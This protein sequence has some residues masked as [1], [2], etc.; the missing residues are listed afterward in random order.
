MTKN[1]ELIVLILVLSLFNNLKIANG[2]L[3]VV[4]INIKKYIFHKFI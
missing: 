3:T 2:K 1:L 4:N